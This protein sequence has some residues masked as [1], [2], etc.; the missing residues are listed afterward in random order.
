MHF[1]LLCLPYQSHIAVFET[2]A[3]ALARRGHRISIVV[4]RGVEPMISTDLSVE[5]VEGTNHSQIAAIIARAARPAG[6]LGI[7]RTVHDGVILS[8]ALCRHGPAML[9]RLGVDAIVGDQM[10]PAAGLI[11]RH[12]GCP[13][14]T[15][16]CAVPMEQDDGVPLPFLSWP[17]DRS[18]KG[19]KRNAGGERVS[20]LLMTEQR[21]MIKRWSIRF[22][23]EERCHDLRSCMSDRATIA[24]LTEGIDFPRCSNQ[25]RLHLLGPLRHEGPLHDLPIE[26]D[27]NR[28]FVFMSLGTLQGHRYRL[29]RTAAK[30]CQALGVQMLVAHC[31]GL[32]ARQEAGLGATWVTD[33][34]PQR[35]VLARADLCITHGG[36][37]TVMDAL[38]AGTPVLALPIAFDQ[39]GLGARI[40]H[41]GVGLRLSPHLLTERAM[42][43]AITRLLGDPAYATRAWEVGRTI[44]GTGGLQ[45][46]V[47]LI[48]TI[49]GEPAAR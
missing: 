44:A 37:N 6:P 38:S 33:Y 27:P 23:L 1:A 8:E 43:A 34:A 47:S 2:L 13:H 29:F 7:L 25:S 45:A 31:G 20:R 21:R 28:P 18:E 26:V 32:N 30:A 22:G 48:E 19:L 10:E 49:C 4:N 40:V 41:H 24:Q 15:L 5:A 46:A 42:K 9:R 14:I 3:V 16:A 17:Y 35:A 36:I 11:A 12:L 39:P